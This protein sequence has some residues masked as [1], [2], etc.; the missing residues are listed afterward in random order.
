METLLF[1]QFYIRYRKFLKTSYRCYFFL[2]KSFFLLHFF[3]F[4]STNTGSLTLLGHTTCP[5]CL[6]CF[7]SRS[8]L[9]QHL[10]IHEP[11]SC[12]MF[13]CSKCSYLSLRRCNVLRHLRSVHKGSQTV[14][15]IKRED[16]HEKS[17]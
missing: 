11:S 13:K 5:K 8:N 7:T 3:F 1:F 12:P 14:I 15:K 2:I 10:R 17:T 6:K 4:S 16:L 9:N